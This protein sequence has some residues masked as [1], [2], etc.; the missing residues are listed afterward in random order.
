MIHVCYALRDESGKYSKFVGTSIQSLLENTTEE[1]TIHILH[2]STLSIENRKKLRQTVSKYK[3]TLRFYYVDE[4]VTEDVE[5]C[6]EVPQLKEVRHG[7]AMFYR[8]F[9]PQLLS[10]EI[11]KAIYLDADIIVNM[12][13]KDLWKINLEE[14]PIGAIPQSFQGVTESIMSVFEPCKDGDVTWD[15]YFN[16]GVLLMDL[17]QLRYD[18][19]NSLFTRCLKVLF[20]HPRYRYLDQD[21]LN[22]IFGK[23]FLKLP[24]KFNRRVDRERKKGNTTQVNREILHYNQQAV[25][26]DL[27]DAFN[28]LWF[29]YFFH[30]PFY[31]SKT[32]FDLVEILRTSTPRGYF[33]WK[34]IANLSATRRRG[35]FIYPQDAQKVVDLVKKNSGDIGFNASFPTSIDELVA[36]MEERRGEMMF[37]IN[38]NKDDFKKIYD[39][40][41]K[42]GF[43][44][45]EDFFNVKELTPTRNF[46]D[47][48]LNM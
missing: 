43:K 36:A 45:D 47:L 9:I 15:D 32:F 23:N 26:L 20:D 31:S 22:F 13:I 8:W 18:G 46:Q 1:I 16:S 25:N 48:V 35:F 28:Q 33:L 21:T 3:Q 5:K 12:D 7:V 19:E 29:E 39:I 24:V 44:K 41:I 17:N 6:L 40:L 4:L 30:T 42:R 14:F 2:D 10:K 34:K 38:V 11:S 27:S 37:F